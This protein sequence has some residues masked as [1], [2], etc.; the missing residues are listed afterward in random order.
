M[1]S[2]VSIFPGA[3]LGVGIGDGLDAAAVGVGVDPGDAFFIGWWECGSAKET[4]TQAT[5]TARVAADWN[6]AFTMAAKGRR[7][8]LAII[9]AIFGVSKA[10]F[11]SLLIYRR[12]EKQKPHRPLQRSMGLGLC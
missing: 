6:L 4:P 1:S 2:G 11:R 8:F 9:V 7:R 10:G 5:K 12:A 3:L